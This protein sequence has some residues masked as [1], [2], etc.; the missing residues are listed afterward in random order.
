MLYE[1]IIFTKMER[2]K[3]KEDGNITFFINILLFI[4]IFFILVFYVSLLFAFQ[5]NI[6]YL[7]HPIL[8]NNNREAFL[9]DNYSFLFLPIPQNFTES[10]CITKNKKYEIGNL[11]ISTSLTEF[12]ESQVVI[13]DQNNFRFHELPSYRPPDQ[14][15]AW[16]MHEPPQNIYDFKLSDHKFNYTINYRHDADMYFPYFSFIK[17][18]SN[19]TFNSPYYKSFSEKKKMICW[20]VSNRRSRFRNNYYH[21]IDKHIKVDVFG[22]KKRVKS[23][24]D[25]ISDYKFYLAFE[26]INHTNYITEKLWYNSFYCG[27]VP[28][29]LGTSKINYLK[30][31][32]P[33]DSFIHVEDF[34][35]ISELAK[36]VLD[37]ANNETL[38]NSYFNWRK[39]RKIWQDNRYCAIM[40][41]FNLHHPMPHKDLVITKW[42]TDNWIH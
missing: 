4:N 21:A 40:E 31:N 38:Y 3:S 26:N 29:V 17:Q 14:L 36:Y 20:V 30:Q 6:M 24:C 19:Y 18:P 2:D 28:I 23:I 7:H 10:N 39:G 35:N 33:A 32:I 34:P 27:A 11:R 25:V 42:Y 8:V 16:F 15:W 1:K 41:F 12:N 37:V 22:G 5:N 9:F 13:L